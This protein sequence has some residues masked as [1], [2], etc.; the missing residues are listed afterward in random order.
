MP[1]PAVSPIPGRL[2][3]TPS[4]APRLDPP[5]GRAP[6]P[7]SRRSGSSPPSISRPTAP[8]PT[9][10]PST[11]CRCGGGGRAP[12]LFLRCPWCFLCQQLFSRRFFRVFPF[13]VFQC[14]HRLLF[15]C[16]LL[17]LS[18]CFA[19]KVFLPCISFL[20]SLL[21]SLHAGM[22][23]RRYSSFACC[24]GLFCGNNFL[25][26]RFSPHFFIF[27]FFRFWIF[28]HFHTISTRGGP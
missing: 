27:G 4:D 20:V 7:S 22:A 13:S 18:V 12:W 19:L 28:L 23:L 15:P 16:F 10:S 3:W 8:P 1:C 26:L 21:P 11:S 24:D 17:F 25:S 2:R 6:P 9:P 5:Q 14:F